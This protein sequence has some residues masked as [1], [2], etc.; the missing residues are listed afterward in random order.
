MIKI[1]KDANLTPK[2]FNISKPGSS[3]SGGGGTR[4][5][6]TTPRAKATPSRANKGTPKGNGSTESANGSTGKRKRGVK[7]ELERDSDDEFTPSTITVAEK[8]SI[9]LTAADLDMTPTKITRGMS[10]TPAPR[11][12]KPERS[13]TSTP[14]RNGSRARSGLDLADPFAVGMNDYMPDLDVNFGDARAAMDDDA[15]LF[16]AGKFDAASFRPAPADHG[17]LPG[18]GGVDEAKN[19]DAKGGA[20]KM[21]D[22][23]GDDGDQF[24]SA[25]E[26]LRSDYAD[27]GED[28]A[29]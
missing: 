25:S 27:D 26:G 20:M 24:A 2:D 7:K 6:N 12:K 3:S 14:H 19:G 17:F 9:G 15:D 23:D 16:G 21:E 22:G 28:L 10:S 18:F 8:R 29:F 5:V 11:G 13:T 4:T 1:R